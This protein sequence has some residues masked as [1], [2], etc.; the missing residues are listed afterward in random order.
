VLEADAR[1]VWAIEQRQ[2]W[3]PVHQADSASGGRDAQGRRPLALDPR[4][5]RLQA[6]DTSC[7]PC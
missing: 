1:N 3:I 6:K 2:G 5:A 4:P 7:S